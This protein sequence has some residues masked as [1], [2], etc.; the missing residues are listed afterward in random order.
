MAIFHP[1]NVIRNGTGFFSH[2]QRLICWHIEK[3]SLRIDEADDQ[4]RAGYSVDLGAPT[5]NP[6][7]VRLL[8]VARVLE[9]AGC[10]LRL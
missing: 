4:P 2:T 8:Q 10:D 5:G 3:R 9:D 1:G 7:M 6:F